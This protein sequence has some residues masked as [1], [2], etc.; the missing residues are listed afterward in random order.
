M[1]RFI[2]KLMCQTHTQAFLVPQSLQIQIQT[3]T[4]SDSVPMFN[5]NCLDLN[6]LAAHLACLQTESLLMGWHWFQH[7]II[8]IIVIYPTA[9]SRC[10]DS[11]FLTLPRA[12]NRLP[13]LIKREL[14]EVRLV[15]HGQTASAISIVSRD[16]ANCFSS[17]S[18]AFFSF[19]VF[20][21]FSFFPSVIL[22]FLLVRQCFPKFKLMTAINSIAQDQQ[23]P[24]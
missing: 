2:F 13:K 10:N 20:F 7:V 6:I 22:A 24:A 18:K 8:D 15:T 5:L 3:H 1:L 23:F 16:P 21:V 11:W 17:D 4:Q 19:L 14:A 12:Q 9:H